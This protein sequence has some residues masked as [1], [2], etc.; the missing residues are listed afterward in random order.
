M[1]AG[2]AAV[3]ALLFTGCA[4]STLPHQ[5]PAQ[6]D[7]DTLV[8]PP[9]P[10]PDLSTLAKWPDQVMAAGD[11]GPNRPGML[12]SPRTYAEAM[13]AESQRRRLLVENVALTN[14]R[15]EERRAAEDLQ[16]ATT[17]RIEEQGVALAWRPWI[18]AGSFVLGAVAAGWLVRQ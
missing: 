8:P 4:T 17:A 6:V 2:V 3:L 1:N 11:C 9:Q 10:P 12:V 14:L 16:R 18:A 13:V 15:R 7:I 5:F